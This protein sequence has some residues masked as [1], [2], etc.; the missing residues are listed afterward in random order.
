ML[1]IVEC[2]FADA[3]QE[4]AWNAWYSG[5]KL[6]E[7]LAVPGFL[8]AQ[9]FRALDPA[10]APYLNVTSIASPELFTSPAYRSGG[11]GRF[12]DWDLAL[13]IDWSR[14][15][16]TGITE[17]PAVPED[18]CLVRL[19]MAPAQAPD[20]G[21]KFVWLSGLD[22]HAVSNYRSAVALDASVP[23]RGLAIVEAH[24]AEA[25]PRLPGLRLYTPI[26]AKRVPSP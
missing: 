8:S 1:Y 3:A 15:L 17:M 23:H 4:A 25:L 10:P 19:D 24:T 16:F 7:L 5:P 6:D 13:V 9:R 26:C 11:G 18:K 21:V 14:R 22:W 12:G 2:G 20:L